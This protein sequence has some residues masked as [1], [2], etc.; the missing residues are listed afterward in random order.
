[1]IVDVHTHIPTHQRKVP[2]RDLVSEEMMRSGDSVM[3]TNSLD[4]YLKDM[5]VVD[6]AILFG[7]APRPFVKKDMGELFGSGK[8]WENNLNHNDLF[9]KK[10]R[11]FSN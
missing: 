8:G 10:I 11:L 2:K 7:I 1:M 3:L 4:D 9:K 6:K 5:E